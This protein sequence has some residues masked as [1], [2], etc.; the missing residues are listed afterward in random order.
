MLTSK[1]FKYCRTQINIEMVQHCFVKFSKNPIRLNQNRF[2]P[3]Q[4]MCTDRQTN[5][6]SDFNR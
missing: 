1:V 5:R 3:S 4:F 6:W 2:I